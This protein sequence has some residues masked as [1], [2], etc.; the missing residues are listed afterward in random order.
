[1]L[2]RTVRFVKIDDWAQRLRER[3]APAGVDAADGSDPDGHRRRQWLWAP[4][5]KR[6]PLTAKRS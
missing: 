4:V 2:D 6:Y 5:G 1:M 3:G